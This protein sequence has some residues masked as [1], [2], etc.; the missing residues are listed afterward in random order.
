MTIDLDTFLTTVYCIIDDWY[1]THAAAQRARRPG[2]RPALSD[3]E[4]LTLSIVAQWQANRSERA[5][6]R[7]VSRH[8]RGYFPTMVSQ[9]DFNRRGRDLVGALSQFGPAL[10]AHL[11]QQ[12]AW[13]AAYSVLDSV[14]VPLMRCCRGRRHRCF[15]DEADLGYGGSDKERYYGVQLL[16]E[17]SQ[18]GLI[19]GFVIGP[20][21][22]DDRWLVEA[23]ARWRQDPSAPA[24]TAEPPPGRAAS[25]SDRPAGAGAGRWPGPPRSPVGRPGLAGGGLA[26]TLAGG[27]WRDGADQGRLRWAAPR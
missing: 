3:S 25:G 22:T 1:Q 5:F 4:V 15:A 16:A 19:T 26:T 27:L 8:W 14:P 10:A 11:S 6:L 2:H 20:A 12:P 13:A 24:P 7:Y 17:V 23:L 9:S 21:S 18:A